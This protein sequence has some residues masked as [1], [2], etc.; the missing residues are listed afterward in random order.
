[1]KLKTPIIIAITLLCAVGCNENT[2]TRAYGGSMT[3][4]LPKGK[5]LV[6]ATWKETELWYLYRDRKE[7]ETPSKTWFKK[8]SSYGVVEGT[9]IFEE[10]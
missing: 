3:V 8:K 6:N 5:T 2:R 1:M 4:E 10:K 9:V 7:G